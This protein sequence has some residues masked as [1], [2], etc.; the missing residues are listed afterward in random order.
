MVGVQIAHFS[1]PCYALHGLNINIALS[2]STCWHTCA[3]LVP[4]EQDLL[5]QKDDLLY[6]AKTME[7]FRMLQ[8]AARQAGDHVQ[9]IQ[10]GEAIELGEVVIASA[11]LAATTAAAAASTSGQ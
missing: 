7:L 10:A 1:L 3:V 9:A 11:G 4:Y 5:V 8:G 2:V 6:S